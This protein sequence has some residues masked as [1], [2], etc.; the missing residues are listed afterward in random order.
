MESP[1]S[2]ASPDWVDAAIHAVPFACPR[3]KAESRE[4]TQVW[5]NRRSPVYLENRRRTWQEFYLCKCGCAW[6]GWSAHR[7]VPDWLKDRVVERLDDDY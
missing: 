2:S 6:W 5:I 7:P 4:A 3:C 1:F